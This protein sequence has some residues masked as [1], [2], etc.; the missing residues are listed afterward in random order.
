M[1]ISIITPTYN[2]EIT[3]RDT[4]ESIIHQNYNNLEY[5]IIDGASSDK[6]LSIIDEYQSRIE[7]K[8]ISEPDKGLYDAMNKGI[9]IASGEIVGILNSDDLYANDKVLNDVANC[10]TKNEKIE[11]CY[12]DISFFNTNN[13]NKVT[14]L[15]KSGEYNENKLNNGWIM[16][17]PSFF[18][19]RSVYQENGG[20]K[21]NFKLAADYELMLR[22]LKVRGLKTQYISKTLV[23]MRTG[24]KSSQ[25]LKQ[26]KLGWS[27]LKK[28]WE[29]NNLK[30]PSFFILRRVLFKLKQYFPIS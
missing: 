20:F 8:V 1:T 5:I 28:S 23:K 22:L 19:K 15:W 12:G 18:L 24:G 26:R 3:I 11:A 10:F 13:P 4:I 16:P 27:E 6:T 29:I 17:H 25:N 2:S 7:I 9:A 30:T 21:E 14:R